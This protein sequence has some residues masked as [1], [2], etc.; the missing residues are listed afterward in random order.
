VDTP[1]VAAFRAAS[2]FFVQ[3]VAA[4]SPDQYQSQWSDEWRV[5]DLIGH[6]NRA[7]VLP[8][9]YY[10]RPVPAAEPDVLREYLLPEN[11]AARGREAVAALGDDPVAG[12]RAASDRALVVVA[13]APDD[14]VIGT[15]FGARSL[16]AYLPSRTAELVLHGLDLDSSVEPPPEALVGCAVFLATQA[17]DS[18]R[19]VDVV[20][21]LS[22]RGTLEPG[23]SVY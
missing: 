14:A 11:I 2:Q 16:A 23:F 18:G 8:V 13:A 6:G 9:E 22:G 3:A 4:V 7:N 21:A 17:V 1:A 10:E 12:V 15:P 19:G 20:R 5:L